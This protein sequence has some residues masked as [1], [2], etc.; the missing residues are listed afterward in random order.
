MSGFPFPSQKIFVTQYSGHPVKRYKVKCESCLF[1][2]KGLLSIT[3]NSLFIPQA[4]SN[5]REDSID[6]L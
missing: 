1:T 6:L 5:N 3:E 4:T 2:H